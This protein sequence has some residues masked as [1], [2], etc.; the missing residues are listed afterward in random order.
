MAHP[1]GKLKARV[2]FGSGSQLTL[3]DTINR[4]SGYSGVDLSVIV[5]EKPD[6]GWIVLYHH[7]PLSTFTLNGGVYPVAVV[8]YVNATSNGGYTGK[9]LYWWNKI[10]R[11]K[12]A[13]YYES[14]MKMASDTAK[15]WNASLKVLGNNTIVIEANPLQ[16]LKSMN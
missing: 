6:N 11:V 2:Y 15:Q 7:S 10:L 5:K 14:I 9:A 12:D 3:N 16:P 13:S 4:V 1:N 8:V